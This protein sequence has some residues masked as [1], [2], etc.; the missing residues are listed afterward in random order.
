MHLYPNP[1]SDNFTVD[2]TI[3][4]RQNVIVSI[5]GMGDERVYYSE[6][7]SNFKGNYH[8][9]NSSF[10]LRKG[11]YIIFIKTDTGNLSKILIK[12]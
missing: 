2:F 3:Q 1:A 11:T 10:K 12:E 7:L 9:D 8:K 6:N 5:A 4:H